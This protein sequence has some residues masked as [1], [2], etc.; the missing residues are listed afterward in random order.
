MAMRLLQ[1]L[2]RNRALRVVLQ[3]LPRI[4]TSFPCR[5]LPWTC[6]EG[7]RS[8]RAGRK[9]EMNVRPI[10]HLQLPE[11]RI[12]SCVMQ[13]YYVHGCMPKSKIHLPSRKAW[14]YTHT[15]T[16][17]QICTSMPAS[18]RAWD[19]HLLHAADSQDLSA[20]MGGGR[21][22]YQCASGLACSVLVG[23]QTCC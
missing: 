17:Q 8:G 15:H 18:C 3:Q 2:H 12:M 4:E 1:L 11:G 5:R 22:L 6:Q 19:A 16:Q 20:G 13:K 21:C 7:W 23:R 10:I 9:Q 14:K